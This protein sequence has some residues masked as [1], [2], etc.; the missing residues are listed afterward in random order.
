MVFD[1]IFGREREENEDKNA[2]VEI[3]KTG[4]EGKKVHI[5]VETLEEYADTD[6]VQKLL[7]EGNILFLK[8]KPLRDKDLGELKRAIA[9]IKKTVTAMNGDIVGVDENYLIVTPEFARVY[10]GASA[11]Q[12]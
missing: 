12:V 6:K 7:R 8:I 10:R 5:R 4:E 3:E 2:F 9:K 1:L 11:T